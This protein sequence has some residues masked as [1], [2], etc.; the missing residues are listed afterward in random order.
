MLNEFSGKT[1]I[2]FVST[3]ST[4]QCLTYMLR[5]LGFKAVCLHGQM[6]QPKRL[7]ALSKFK[8]GSRNIL[9]A[10]D[11]ASRGLDVAGVDMVINYDFPTNGKD[12]IHRVGRTARAGRSGYADSFIT[13]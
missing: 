5:N 11:V 7:S 1:T 6:P 2:L 9:I 12:Y 3:C 8:E 4:A 10:T 13:Q